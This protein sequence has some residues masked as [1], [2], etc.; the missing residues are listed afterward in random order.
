MSISGIFALT[1]QTMEGTFN[2]GIV[3]IEIETYKLDANNQ[4]VKYNEKNQIVMPGTVV[5]LI[6]KVKNLGADCYIRM[7]VSLV[8]EN[9][10]LYNHTIGLADNWTKHGEYY[11]YNGIVKS[12]D[13][14]KMFE[15]IQ[16]PKNLTNEYEGKELNLEIIVEAIQS[17]NFEPDY[18]LDDPWK[19]IK[20]EKSV[21][22]SYGIEQDKKD[23]KVTIK[24]ENN[25]SNNITVPAN[26]LSKLTSLMPGDKISESIEIKN[27]NKNNV[28][29]FCRIE[30]DETNKKDIELLNQIGLIITNQN[31][32]V[33]YNGKLLSNGRILLGEYDINEDDKLQYNV[34][35]PSEL[36]NDFA[37][38][39][40]K[41]SVIYSAEG[42]EQEIDQKGTKD[43]KT[44]E[45]TRENTKDNPQTGD[46]IN[47][48]II[49]FF[50]STAGLIIVMIIGYKAK[51]KEEDNKE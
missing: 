40:P 33:V 27:K 38:L 26:F 12:S 23:S 19:N 34:S 48:T 7:K 31:G 1:G 8:C 11:Y 16:I 51:K 28:K 50:I 44:T 10:S 22:D 6:P 25:T 21:K 17:I 42:N 30:V 13:T 36:S 43:D 29:Y 46:S 15:S 39:S 4:E 20:P 18:S 2:T 49:I 41:F 14:V 9:T 35:I 3:D 32:K 47:M 37:L 45:N 5:S 24:F